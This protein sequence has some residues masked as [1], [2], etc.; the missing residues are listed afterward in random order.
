MFPEVELDV[1]GQWA[2]FG[3]VSIAGRRGW[4]LIIIWCQCDG[5]VRVPETQGEGLAGSAAVGA[6]SHQFWICTGKFNKNTFDRL[7]GTN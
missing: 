3:V 6:A 2:W 1:T 5:L 7:Q 4:I